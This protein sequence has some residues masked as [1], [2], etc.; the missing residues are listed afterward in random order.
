MC[1]LLA[2][3]TFEIYTTG[4]QTSGKLVGPQSKLGESAERWGG[5]ELNSVCGKD[6]KYRRWTGQKW[7]KNF[8]DSV[9]SS[10]SAVWNQD[11]V[12]LQPSSVTGVKATCVCRIAS[13]LDTVAAFLIP[14]ELRKN[15]ICW[16]KQ[17]N[18][19]SLK[20]FYTLIRWFF[21][22]RVDIDIFWLFTSPDVTLWGWADEF[23][24]IENG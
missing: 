2:L 17:L 1:H 18:L 10:C 15:E 11:E 12:A 9:M 19:N 6:L 24:S 3:G 14:R 4:Q 23:T 20:G 22:G 13:K 8:S 16:R 5:C 21:F 7:A